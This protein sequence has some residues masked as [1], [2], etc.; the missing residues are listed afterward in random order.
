MNDIF[1]NHTKL[2]YNNDIS[3]NNIENVLLIDSAV[4][5]HNIFM[6]ASN[7]NTFPIIYSVLSDRKE[8]LDLLNSKFTN[9]KRIGLAFHTYTPNNYHMFLN[10]D[11]LFTSYDLS[12]NIY[13]SNCSFIINI[14]KQFS[15]ANIDFLACNTLN[16][17]K[18]IAFYNILNTNTNVIV[19]ASN[20]NTGNILYGGDWIMESTKEDIQ[21]IYF[22]S[23]ISNYHELLFNVVIPDGTTD[24]GDYAYAGQSSLESVSIPSS[25]T[26]IGVLAFYACEFYFTSVVIPP[27]VSIGSGAF[28][29]CKAMQSVTFTS[30]YKIYG[31]LYENNPFTED[32]IGWGVFSNLQT[33]TSFT[34]PDTIKYIASYALSNMYM[35]SSIVIPPSMIHVY[36]FAFAGFHSLTNLTLS[37]STVFDTYAFRLDFYFEFDTPAVISTITMLGDIDIYKSCY[38]LINNGSPQTIYYQPN[39]SGWESMI[40]TFNYKTFIPLY[41][42]YYKDLS[43]SI[44]DIRNGTSYIQYS[45]NGNDFFDM[46]GNILLIDCS[47][48]LI[49]SI[50]ISNNY[51]FG[52]K[53]NIYIEGNNN[54][55][56]FSYNGFDG[57]FNMSDN[58]GNI[59]INNVKMKNDNCILND[60]AFLIQN[61]AYGNINIIN[62]SYNGDITDDNASNSAFIGSNAGINE[63]CSVNFINC[64]SGNVSGNNSSNS[65]FIGINTGTNSCIATFTN[66]Y[67]GSVSGI[68]A[69]NSIFVGVNASGNCNITFTNC[70]A[71][72]ISESNNNSIFIGYSSS[73]NG[74]MSHCYA[75]NDSIGDTANL[76]LSNCGYDVVWTNSNV[77]NYLISD[78]NIL[79]P[80]VSLSV[81]SLLYDISNTI[82]PLPYPYENLIWSDNNNPWLLNSFNL[83]EYQYDNT[84]EHNQEL[85]TNSS[86][87]TLTLNSDIS[88]NSIKVCYLNNNETVVYDTNTF[89]ISNFMFDIN[90]YQL[91]ATTDI[92]NI[93]SS[94]YS[95]NII[96]ITKTITLPDG[97]LF[98]CLW[99]KNNNGLNISS[100]SGRYNAINYN[101]TNILDNNS[102]MNQLVYT[103]MSGNKQLILL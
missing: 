71:G 22:T 21:N 85:F 47:L 16:Y 30:P 81:Q 11:P 26:Y 50:N 64:Y 38:A 58:A 69:Q 79:Y 103:D 17:D 52:I 62:C 90:Y 73:C 102:N 83:A 46:S 7:E 78:I 89:D 27:S 92:N 41:T 4:K 59:T 67:S 75:Q 18:W 13:S 55:I 97:V 65:A 20:D 88:Y 94:Q 35:V 34:I 31:Q 76:T 24:I 87:I 19:G 42:T 39:T 61:N 5:N 10:M 99:I 98:R 84:I 25:V 44:I 72:S 68:S 100:D 96:S 66:C 93:Q 1:F 12:D 82:C 3:T 40:S 53:N 101:I 48:N 80:I 70:Y 37:T 51:Y 91:I 95:I 28:A 56:T 77:N 86:S 45:V 74:S 49:E 32:A 63:N 23:D 15:V 9:I 2:I 33:I 57:L 54:T 14:I 60:S 6:T 36:D 8:L 29:V 43:N